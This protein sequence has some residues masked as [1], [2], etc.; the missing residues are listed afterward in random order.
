M[1]QQRR[2]TLSGCTPAVGVHWMKCVPHLPKV[3]WWQAL[4]RN[5]PSLIII[6]V[7]WKGGEGNI[8][9]SSG[10][11][12]KLAWTSSRNVPSS[13]AAVWHKHGMWCRVSAACRLSLTFLL[14]S[15]WPCECSARF[16]QIPLLL[17]LCT[18]AEPTLLIGD[19]LLIWLGSQNK[20]LGVSCW[21]DI[22][23]TVGV[24]G[25]FQ[26]V[27]LQ[28]HVGTKGINILGGGSVKVPQHC[29]GKPHP[30]RFLFHVTLQ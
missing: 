11:K 25:S 19:Y 13:Q 1:L 23:S 10:F 28:T 18:A 6:T 21:M 2:N 27:Q 7:V 20:P 9:G 5:A 17:L 30:R 16:R 29:I 15:P 24:V 12:P 26:Q 4:T 22:I 3:E 14:N 8:P